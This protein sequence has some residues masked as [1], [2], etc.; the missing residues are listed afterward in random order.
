MI[1]NL[2]LLLSRAPGTVQ[3]SAVQCGAVRTNK[4]QTSLVA[5]LS[6]PGL[7]RCQILADGCF[8]LRNVY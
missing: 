5:L 4:Q 2:S 6:W 8:V 7:R 3:S 1:N